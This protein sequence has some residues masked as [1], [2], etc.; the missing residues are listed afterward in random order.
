MIDQSNN[1]HMELFFEMRKIGNFEIMPCN[2][3]VD[4]ENKNGFTKLT[5]SSAQKMHIS[6][7]LQQ[8]P[9]TMAVGTMA[10]TYKVVFPEGLPHTLMQL[11]DGGVG[12]P[13]IGSD[14]KIMA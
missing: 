5:L 2:N 7:L 6:A 4:C 3:P 13:I 9:S 14:G 1:E 11:G 12:S 10:Q 8:V